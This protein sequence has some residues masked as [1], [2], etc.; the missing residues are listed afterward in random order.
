MSNIAD[1]SQQSRIGHRAVP[2]PSSTAISQ[3]EGRVLDI[4]VGSG[5]SLPLYTNRAKE[6]I[7]LEPHPKLLKM[8]SEKAGQVP[9]KLVEGLAE[10]IPLDDLS[11]DA[12]V[13]GWQDRLTLVWK[14][15]AGGCHL[16]RPI[17]AL[18]EA[19]GFDVS[20]LETGYMRGPKPMTFVYQG[21]AQVSRNARKLTAQVE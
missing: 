11:P 17:A 3:A 4:G 19:V 9:F 18:V 1:R 6:V 15:V 21:I 7:G 5:L 13:T 20:Q 16:N 2:N 8:A 14:R 12:K 10:S